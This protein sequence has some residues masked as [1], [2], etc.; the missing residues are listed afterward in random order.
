MPSAAI[1]EL[2][3][4]DP[5][6]TAASIL[7]AAPMGP[8]AAT[9]TPTIG[10]LQAGSMAMKWVALIEGCPYVT[11]NATE[12]AVQAAYAGTDWAT[13]TAVTGLFVD[14]HNDQRIDPQSAFATSGQC[15][16]RILDTDGADTFGT[17][18]HKR[19]VGGETEITA[20]VDRDDTTINVKSTTGFT[21]SGTIF[22]G[23]EA[24]SYTGTTATSFTGCTRGMYSPFS[25]DSSGSGTRFANHHRWGVDS[26]YIQAQ[27]VVTQLPRVWIGRRVAVYLHTWDG[28][29]INSRVNAQLVY[30][31]RIVGIADDPDGFT[32][33]LELEHFAR[34][35][36]E[37]VIGKD[38]FQAN[39][40]QGMWIAAGR[41][42]GFVDGKDG[43]PATALDLDVVASGATAPYEINEGFYSLSEICEAWNAWLAQAKVDGDINGTY[44]WDSPVSYR[45]EGLRTVCTWS[46]AD[47][48]TVKVSWS[49]YAP[50]EVLAFLGCV[51]GVEPA[52]NGAMVGFQYGTDK[53]S[54]I[55]HQRAGFSVPYQSVVFRPYGPGRLGQ[56]YADAIVYDLENE[57]GTFQDQRALL[58]SAIRDN[59]VAGEVAG[60]FMLDGRAL[61]VGVYDSTNHRF[62]N[63]WLAPYRQASDKDQES[64]T[65]I[66]RRADEPQEPINVRQVFVLEGSTETIL[67]TLAYSTGA[68]GFNHG[69]YDTLGN[70][71]G[72]GIP[73]SLL[74]SEFE[75][76]ISNLP[77]ADKPIVVV[78]DEPT[79]LSDLIGSDLRIRRAFLRWKDQ[80]FNFCQW[81]T[82]V[83]TAAIATL[84]ESNKAEPSG[85]VANQR[86]ISQETDEHQ[87]TSVVIDYERDFAS[88]REAKYLKTVSIEDQGATDETDGASGSRVIT[89][90]MRNTY[91]DFTNT[92]AGVESLIPGL[93]KTMPLFSRAV[94]SVSRSIDHRYFEGYSVG[95]IVTITDAFA[96]DPI[97][98]RRAI[99]SRPA[100]IT[101][102]WYDLSGPSGGVELLFLDLHR[103]CAYSPSAD[104]DD[105]ATFGGF[106]AGYS[107]G[108]QTIRCKPHAFSHLIQIQT[109][110]GWFTV[111]EPR[112]AVNFENGDVVV[113]VERDPSNP[114]SPLS[115]TAEV[116]A[117]SGDD[118]SLDTSLTGWDNTKRYRIISAPYTSATATQ[119]DDAYQADDTDLLIQDTDPPCNYSGLSE[120]Y[121]YEE[122]G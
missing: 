4:S 79:R 6:T 92:G 116:T 117:V 95:D 65:Y 80:G 53:Y 76:S 18:V 37:C 93:M 113:V 46:I 103:G 16:L 47:A 62:K 87:R 50:T 19:L 68:A 10:K 119:Q 36:Q 31:G 45:H 22:I 15:S 91:S 34:E 13:A 1:V 58:P 57:R 41:K 64:L 86:S 71:L 74:G 40:P 83:S 49:I 78:I 59:I 110:R 111:A 61:M 17:Y 63:C 27:P 101:R 23:C 85:N 24:I 97:T 39:I 67:N 8:Y 26:R 120:Q 75:R 81:Q 115:W 98:G 96:R 109:K 121:D 107:S 73:G 100:V 108:T 43:V 51:D 9:D 3:S 42:F 94:H 104:I 21:S 14:L 5:T 69:T 7:T 77:G 55:T 112:D 48:G 54:N 56:E 32:T 70:G 89:L 30:A 2:L 118:V 122:N 25:C 114:A 52:A 11:T 84:S 12:A 102:H 66:G 82:P 33:K 90:K 35:W 28:T 88:G 20:T 106:D 105:T 38:M 60:L 99:V 29:S 72:V 44:S